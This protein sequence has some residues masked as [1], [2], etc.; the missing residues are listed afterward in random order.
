MNPQV[1]LDETVSVDVLADD[2]VRKLF[3]FAG[4]VVVDDGVRELRVDGN[5]S[6][7]AVSSSSIGSHPVRMVLADGRTI[8]STVRV[9]H[10]QEVHVP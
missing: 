4:T 2:H 1:D 8:A 10:G 9:R 6:R 3:K 5:S 7:A